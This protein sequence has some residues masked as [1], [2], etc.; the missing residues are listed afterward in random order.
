MK[1]LE[2]RH[3]DLLSG[4]EVWFVRPDHIDDVFR[5]CVTSNARP[6]GGD[7]ASLV[8]ATD[9]ELSTGTLHG[10][11]HSGAVGL[12]L[13]PLY[14]VG[15]GYPL[16]ADPSFAVR[17]NRDLTPSV[18]PEFEP[19]TPALAGTPVSLGTGGADAYLAF[20]DEELKPALAEAFPLDPDDA[21]LTGQSFGGLFVVHALLT[22]PTAFRRYLAGS[23]SLW[24]HDRE[25]L[26]LA[27]KAVADL[28][29]PRAQLYL[30]IG[31][32]EN[33]ARFGRQFGPMLPESVRA[34]LPSAMSE[35]DMQGDFFLL[36]Q[37]LR[38]WE[39]EEFSVEA[40]MFPQESHESIT[41]AMLSRGLRRLHGYL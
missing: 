6:T 35:S 29:A 39:G 17:R 14:A 3:D 41:G 4:A 30:C 24:W 15:V 40:H 36:E 19:V 33:K 18:W 7:R 16:D 32:L 27:R 38:E 9:A 34:L 21:T 22:R 13:P 20:L 25:T 23:P 37:I 1:I 11:V 2:K 12:D 28:P 26:D 5:V 8:I 10:L 31:E